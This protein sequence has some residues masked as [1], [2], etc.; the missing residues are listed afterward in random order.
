MSET[1]QANPN[2]DR[3]AETVFELA[4]CPVVAVIGTSGGT[5]EQLRHARR[6]GR[7]LASA[8]ATVVTGG[9]SGVMEAAC[10]GATQ[11]GGITIGILP[12]GCEAASPPNRFVQIPI[13]TG[14]GEAANAVVV[15][16]AGAVI[17]IGGGYGTLSEIGLA[18]KARRPV[19]CLDSWELTAPD[20]V[21]GMDGLLRAA[22]TPQEAVNMAVA[23]AGASEGP[24]CSGEA[25]PSEPEPLPDDRR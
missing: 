14:M 6:V 7:L 12:G 15:Q 22:K 2:A 1:D 11:V 4:R 17:A 9:R 3:P 16:T 5:T 23:L 10:Q 13:Y 19:I 25:P 8:G 20:P 21:P 24:S 18:L